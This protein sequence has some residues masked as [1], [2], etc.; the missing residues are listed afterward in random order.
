M[1][2]YPSRFP[3]SVLYLIADWLPLCDMK[4]GTQ[5]RDTVLVL[6]LSTPSVMSEENGRRGNMVY[7]KP[8]GQER[9][10]TFV[11]AKPRDWNITLCIRDKKYSFPFSVQWERSDYKNGR[12][13]RKK[14]EIRS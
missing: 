13:V 7:S 11:L 3:L 8:P 14:S 10:K 4:P 6:K 2:Q 5:Q 12:A 1:A 9:Q